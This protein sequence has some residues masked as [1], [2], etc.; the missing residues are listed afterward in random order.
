MAYCTEQSKDRWD[1]IAEAMMNHGCTERWS[2]EQ[3]EKKWQQLHPEED[4]YL[5]EDFNHDSTNH[6][7]M[8]NDFGVED[9]T[10]MTSNQ[11]LPMSSGQISAISATTMED[12]RSRQASDASSH[13]MQLQQTHMIFDHQQQ[14]QSAWSHGT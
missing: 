9:W 4:D 1:L 6:L 3:V 8:N 5:E 12:V 7:Q 11:G 10:S 13:H 14:E 2:K